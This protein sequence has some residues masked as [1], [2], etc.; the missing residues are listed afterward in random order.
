MKRNENGVVRAWAPDSA[1]SAHSVSYCTRTGTVWDQN[2]SLRCVLRILLMFL[3]SCTPIAVHQ[4]IRSM[5][6]AGE[7]ILF[8]FVRHS[9]AYIPS[10]ESSPF[11]AESAFRRDVYRAKLCRRS[12]SLLL[13]VRAQ[14]TSRTS[15]TRLQDSNSTEASLE[16]AGN[17]G[18]RQRNIMTNGTTSSKESAAAPG[19][20]RGKCVDLFGCPAATTLPLS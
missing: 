5:T 17:R 18:P 19:C 11:Y 8:F 9:V 3:W 14:A 6:I 10:G 1:R 12:F 2:G 16:K 20:L 15:L 7:E 13:A 4:F